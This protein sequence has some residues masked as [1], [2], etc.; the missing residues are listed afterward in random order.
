M[1]SGQ[2]KIK[3]IFCIQVWKEGKM[4]IKCEHGMTMII[5]KNYTH[6]W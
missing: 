6:I 4:E 5:W 1:N 2:K 3:Y